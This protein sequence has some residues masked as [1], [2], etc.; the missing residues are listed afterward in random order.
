M[1]SLDLELNGGIPVTAKFRTIGRNRRKTHT[2]GVQ[3]VNQINAKMALSTNSR[4]VGPGSDLIMLLFRLRRT[5]P[6]CVFFRFRPI[7]LNLAVNCFVSGPPQTLDKESGALNPLRVTES[8][9]TVGR[10]PHPSTRSHEHRN[11]QKNI[12]DCRALNHD[13]LERFLN[14]VAIRS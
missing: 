11:H 14:G 9:A 2:G 12:C 6:I 10:V 5:P 3:I 13:I 1:Y 4:R 8:I 7:V